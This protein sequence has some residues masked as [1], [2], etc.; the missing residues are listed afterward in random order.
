MKSDRDGL[1]RLSNIPGLEPKESPA[2]L[3]QILDKPA[4]E[5][6]PALQPEVEE[7]VLAPVMEF[8]L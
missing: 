3:T 8:L 1:E 7:Y 5:L 4:P 2:D 6:T